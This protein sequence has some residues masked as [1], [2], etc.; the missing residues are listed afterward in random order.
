MGNDIYIDSMQN[1]AENALVE[2][3]GDYSRLYFY[4][5]T[6][7]AI[8]DDEFSGTT[9]KNSIK[10]RIESLHGKKDDAEKTT[11][12]GGENYSVPIDSLKTEELPMAIL[13]AQLRAWC[14]AWDDP[15]AYDNKASLD[16]TGK[17]DIDG[18]LTLNNNPAGKEGMLSASVT[19]PY[20][21]YSGTAGFGLGSPSSCSG[22]ARLVGG[23]NA[24]YTASAELK[25]D[26]YDKMNLT[27]QKYSLW[28]FNKIRQG[29]G[30]LRVG[31]TVLV[32][33]I[34]GR[35]NLLFIHDIVQFADSKV[36][37]NPLMVMEEIDMSTVKNK[38]KDEKTG[39]EIIEDYVSANK[40]ARK[41]SVDTLI[42]HHTA[43]SSLMGT[44][45]WFQDKNSG[46]SAHYVVGKKGEVFRMVPDNMCAYHAGKSWL[47]D[48]PQNEN[49][50]S[51][52]VND[53]SIGIELVNIGDNVD[54]YTEEQMDALVKLVDLIRRNNPGIL[55]KNILGH[56]DVAPGRKT[57]PSDNFDWSRLG[58]ARPIVTNDKA[59]E[60][61]RNAK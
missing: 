21:P 15:V 61:R 28:P 17:I 23:H 33:P 7:E 27:P 25:T 43:S 49:K 19:T 14:M 30:L 9:A 11:T 54:P 6:I 38:T 29:K 4:I 52:S 16:M 46:V 57:D 31:D 58:L 32:S 10:V 56:R 55:E 26:E 39:L 60:A 5:G 37:T 8:D 12:V 47:P 42:I 40:R 22:G 53:R 41:E 18:E 24:M 2:R 51:T 50:K 13:S 20:G 36:V 45:R 3:R 35:M 34:E 48:E 44:V 1:D 59:A